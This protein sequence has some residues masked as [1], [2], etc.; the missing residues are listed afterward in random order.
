VTRFRGTTPD[1]HKLTRLLA[2]LADLEEGNFELKGASKEE[3]RERL[4]G[5]IDKLVAKNVV[6]L[7]DGLSHSRLGLRDE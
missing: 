2:C 7:N 3:V 4:Q 5:K 1:R 6:V